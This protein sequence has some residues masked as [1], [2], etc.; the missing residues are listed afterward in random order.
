[1]PSAQTYTQSSARLRRVLL[2]PYPLEP[3]HHVRRQP[4]G[5]FLAH[6]RRHR[7]AHP[8]RRY[9]VQVQPR[10]RSV[11]TRAAANVRRH[12]G[13]AKRRR[14]PRAAAQLR[15]FDLH[16]ADPRQDLPPRK[17]A[18]ADH[19]PP[20]V[21]QPFVREPRQALLELRR[22]RRLDQP[23]RARAQQLRQRVLNHRWRRET[24]LS[25]PM[26]GVLLSPKPFFPNSISAETRRTTQLT[27]TPLSTIA[28][29][30]RQKCTKA[31]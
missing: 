1:M 11:E 8:A 26:C 13:R 18:V 9:P 24:T 25:L 14:R 30:R 20:S 21:R 22:H 3:A 7:R 23:S 31:K 4:A 27:R 5:R 12:Q 29:G 16:R 19:P 17:V 15:N 10:N 28:P 6:Q 2:V